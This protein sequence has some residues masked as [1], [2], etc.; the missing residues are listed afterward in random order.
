MTWLKLS[1]KIS[2]IINEIPYILFFEN[3]GWNW[4]FTSMKHDKRTEI[5]VKVLNR[6]TNFYLKYNIELITFN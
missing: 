6:L 4:F 1:F 5:K 2:T 3:K